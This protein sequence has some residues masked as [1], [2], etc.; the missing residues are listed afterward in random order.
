M[1]GTVG[2]RASLA[3]VRHIYKVSSYAVTD[4]GSVV[5][6][7]DKLIGQC[8]RATNHSVFHR[9]LSNASEHG[10]LVGCIMGL[11]SQ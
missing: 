11:C 10:P 9:R 8:C 7:C 3:F 2:W 4:E 1:L 5:L 6:A